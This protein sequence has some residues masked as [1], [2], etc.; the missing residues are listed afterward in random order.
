MSQ[1]LAGRHIVVTRPAGQA[2]H[3]AEALVAAGA[4]PVLFPVLA[5]APLTDNSTLVAQIIRLDQYDLAI[6]ISPNAVQMALHEVLS[7][8]P[9]PTHLRVATVGRSSEAALQAHDLTGQERQVLCP[10]GRFDSEALLELPE[11]QSMEDRRVIIFRGDGGRE[12]LADTLRQ[13]GASVDYANCYQ[14]SMPAADPA[15]L[16]KLWEAG[17]LDAITVTSSEGL[18]N[19]AHMAGQLG[20]AWLRKTPLF[21]PHTRIAAAAE[22]FGIHTVILTEPADAGLLVGLLRY[23]SHDN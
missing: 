18:H 22:A 4:H 17:Q 12:L 1:P 2:T 23:F 13:R 16:L 15:P 20:L 6:F 8:R 5:I 14:R 10:R 11:L 7:R 19:L 21:V 3:L 9:W